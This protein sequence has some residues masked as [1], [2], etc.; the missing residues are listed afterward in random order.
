M[1]SQLTERE[2]E[3]LGFFYDPT[4]MTE[5]LIPR[6]FNSPQIW[7]NCQTVETRPYQFAMQ[8]YSYLIADDPELSQ[9]ENFK[10]KK[11]SGDLYSIGSR[12]T[13]K[14]FYLIIDVLLSIIFK[15]KE[16]C[17]ASV[18]AEKL[19]KV[20]NP[21]AKFVEAHKFIK[22]FHLRQESTRSKTVK[23][24]PLT[25]NT[26]HGAT[27]LNV[28]E[29]V[30]GD[31]PGVQFHSK[32]YDIRWTEEFSYSTKDGQEKAEDAEMSYGHIERP[33]G[34]PDLSIDSPLGKILTNKKLKNFLWK[35][36]Q[37]VREDWNEE[38]EQ[39]K[40][41]RYGGR[42]S[43]G[44]LLNVEAKEMEGAFGFF[45]MARLKEMSIKKTGKVKAFEIGKE[46]FQGFE[47]RLHIERMAGAEQ[48]YV[49]ADIGTGSAPTEIIIVFFDGKKY[50]YA[51]NIT[52]YRL[53]Q[54]E[55][56]EIF[57]W[58]YDTLQ[59]AYVAI[60]AS[61]DGGVIIDMLKKD[62]IEPEH[63]LKVKFYENIEVGFEK[64]GNGNAV[65]DEYGD[66]VMKKADTTQWSYKELE[67]IMYGGTM[68]I[69]S[70]PKLE[71]QFSNIICKRTK[72]KT[73]Y[74]SKGPNHLV[75]AWQVFSICRFFNEFNILRQQ[76][77]KKRS[78]GVFNK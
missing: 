27:I 19:K 70:D 64:D 28:N 73:L 77:K 71:E 6:T 9:A 26:E 66:P 8:N 65:T 68:E 14:S 62:G 4:A 37:Y 49:T 3:R 20:A 22:I 18:T 55:Q 34:I 13:G 63:L 72:M 75:Q 61:H 58:L 30:D 59:G 35:L 74:D 16:G 44:Y 31:N 78:F 36:P 50:K 47:N 53:L 39:K 17:V 23:R 24:D 56:K 52:L 38:L 7:P 43:A 67:K 12:N 21:I 54:E 76:T 57:K 10:R 45:D 60:D 29:K 15:C 11:L 33:S 5:I 40:I 32:H 25:I 51:Y 2:I 69:P 1:Q 41:D 42:N 48:C 46:S